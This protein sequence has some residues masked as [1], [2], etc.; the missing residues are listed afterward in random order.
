MEKYP[1]VS[2][3][4]PVYNAEK[5]LQRCIDSIVNQTY[6][7]IEVIVVN[8][9]ST[10]SSE[11]I[12]KS[13]EYVHYIYQ[14]NKGVSAARNAGLNVVTGDYILFV[15]SDDYCE[16][17]MVQELVSYINECEMVYCAYYFEY[18]DKTKVVKNVFDDGIYSL[19]DVFEALFFGL[20][21]INETE[22]STSLWRYLFKSDII[23]NYNIK[24]DEYI[25]YAEDWLFY[26]EYCKYVSNIYL[27]NN[28]LYHYNQNPESLTHTFRPTTLLGITKSIYILNKWLSLV[29]NSNI[30][31]S[32]YEPL[33][34][35][36]YLNFVL[37]QSKN[38]WNMKNPS[39]VKEKKS[40]VLKSILMVKLEE[41]LKDFE[42]L[43]FSIMERLLLWAITHKKMYII[44][45]YSIL[46]NLLR[47]LRNFI[48]R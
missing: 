46:Y 34:A 22:M 3:V 32:K 33:I 16:P 12:A 20:R 25:R 24:F 36:R 42:Y 11:S 17:T 23:K 44:S 4:V 28:T 6:Q 29:R 30:E 10:D 9:G 35:K 5:Y 45:I 2:I 31:K 18:G 37:N 40:L 47:D 27:T 1:K 43:E 26:T 13:C 48:R 14:E 39:K 38:V 19:S 21:N 15:D 41:K 7:N 8:D